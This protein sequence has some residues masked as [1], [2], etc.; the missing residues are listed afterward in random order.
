MKRLFLALI[1]AWLML[2]SLAG[3]GSPDSDT[4]LQNAE[5]TELIAEV[6]TGVP[7]ETLDAIKS[8]LKAFF[9]ERDEDASIYVFGDDGTLDISL[10]AEGMVMGFQTVFPDYA[11]A[12][13][14]QSQELAA[15]YDLSI[16]QISVTFTAGEDNLRN[17]TTYDCISGILADTYD[18]GKLVLVDQTIEDLVDRY[19]TEGWFYP[20]DVDK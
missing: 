18:G 17:W 1:L 11:N 2:V 3:C 6:D 14:I 8:A 10:D 15:E 9:S 13:V 4:P 12:L 5:S 20:I 7:D 19:G 16:S